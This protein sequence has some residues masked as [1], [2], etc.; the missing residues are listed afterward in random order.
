MR[1]IK[2]DNQQQ[3]QLKRENTAANSLP[4]NENTPPSSHMVASDTADDR[5]SKSCT[6]CQLILSAAH[7][8]SAEST[9]METNV[10]TEPDRVISNPNQPHSN[11]ATQ[12][13]LESERDGSIMLVHPQSPVVDVI[14]RSETYKL[15]YLQSLHNL[16]KM[17][18]EWETKYRPPSVSVYT[19]WGAGPQ[20]LYA[21]IS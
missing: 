15:N 5:A 17:L 7:T 2:G 14:W 1:V 20:N 13:V 6:D 3:L 11:I 21:S 16:R 10:S 4:L 12:K 8:D 18:A 9:V 19:G